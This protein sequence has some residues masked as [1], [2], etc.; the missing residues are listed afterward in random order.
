MIKSTNKGLFVRSVVSIKKFQLARWP[1]EKFSFHSR[2][3]QLR[4]RVSVDEK[5]AFLRRSIESKKVDGSN[6]WWW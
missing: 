2:I 6:K 4:E 3:R 5:E 1:I